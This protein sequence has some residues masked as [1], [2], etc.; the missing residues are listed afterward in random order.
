M[1]QTMHEMPWTAAGVLLAVVFGMGLHGAIFYEADGK[2]LRLVADHDAPARTGHHASRLLQRME[3]IVDCGEE[4]IPG[5]TVV[6]GLNEYTVELSVPV[7]GMRAALVDAQMK[8]TQSFGAY[9]R[10][11]A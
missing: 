11:M 3:S 5:F 1:R 9:R 6:V 2:N 7:A 10:S 4:K 8:F